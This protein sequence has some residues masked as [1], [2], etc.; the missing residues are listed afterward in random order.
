[1]KEK[2]KEEIQLMRKYERIQLEVNSL[3]GVSM[4]DQNKIHASLR[5]FR[6]SGGLTLESPEDDRAW[7]RGQAKRLGYREVVMGSGKKYGTMGEGEFKLLKLDYASK[8]DQ[9]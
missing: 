7:V 8:Q 4:Q 6:K 1:M 9:W 5:E 2:T 3:F